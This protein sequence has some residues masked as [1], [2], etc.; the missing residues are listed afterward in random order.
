[1]A[2]SSYNFEIPF[3]TW[4]QLSILYGIPLI[5]T[6]LIAINGDPF[7]G[8]TAGSSLAVVMFTVG[9]AL[10]FGKRRVIS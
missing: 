3:Y 9:T 10:I 8:W 7:A 4:W 2:N 1:M 6:A 5:A